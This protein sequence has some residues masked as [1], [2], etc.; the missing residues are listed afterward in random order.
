MQ[1]VSGLTSQTMLRLSDQ[2]LQF[3]IDNIAYSVSDNIA[4]GDTS[5]WTLEH[6]KKK[7]ICT[8]VFHI[9]AVV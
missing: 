4:H 5:G 7:R 1:N 3:Y 9:S 6:D 8:L 2:M